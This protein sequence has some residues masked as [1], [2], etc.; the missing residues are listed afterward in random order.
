MALSKLGVPEPTIKLI[1]SFHCDMQAQMR[2]AEMVTMEYMHVAK[3]FGLTLSIP[4]TKVMAVG[5]EVKRREREAVSKLPYLGSQIQSFG[6]VT[7]DAEKRIAQAFKAFGALRR[8]V[9][10]DHDLNTTMK[11]KVYQAYVLTVLLYGSQCW[12]P[13]KK[14]LKKLNSFHNRCVRTILGISNKQQW[15]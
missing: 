8:P 7:L 2:G 6:R 10:L 13:L 14:D 15:S 4:K 9:F 1:R 12:T 3:D 11:R 5:R